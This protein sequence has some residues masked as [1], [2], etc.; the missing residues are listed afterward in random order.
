MTFEGFDQDTA[1]E[2]D[3]LRRALPLVPTSGT[4]RNRSVLNQATATA[5]H[6]MTASSSFGGANVGRCVEML[7]IRP[8]LVAAAWKV[9]DLLLEA[10][11]EH[12]GTVTASAKVSIAAK[13]GLARQHAGRPALFDT[14]AWHALCEVYVSTV[15]LRHSLVHRRVH[16]TKSHALV[17]VGEHG[18]P[19][20]PLTAEEQDAFARTAQLAAEIVTTVD[21]DDRTHAD[22][23]RQLWYLSAL[24]TVE[25]EPVHLA[26]VPPEWTVIVEPVVGVPGRYHL[27]LKMLRDRVAPATH[28]DVVVAFPDRSGQELVGRFEM[29]PAVDSTQID[30]NNPPSWLH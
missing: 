2:R 4:G 16:L 15:D 5:H 9:L 20:Q 24:H 7:G 28:V 26:A 29:A 23:K 30:A 13:E 6:F 12:A 27:N 22:L 11:F 21:P 17:G 1:V 19:L 10:A 8:L 3:V 14:Q 18:K 25:L